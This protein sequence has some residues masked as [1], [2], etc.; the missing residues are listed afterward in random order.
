MIDRVIR[1]PGRPTYV[2]KGNWD[3][4]G[5]TDAQRE[6]ELEKMSEKELQKRAKYNEAKR[7]LN[8]LNRQSED[9]HNKL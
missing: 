3:L 9:S 6:R 8:D 1:T 5:A 2:D 4:L 7:V